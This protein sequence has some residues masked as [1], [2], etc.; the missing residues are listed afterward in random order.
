LFEAFP[1]LSFDILSH[2][3]GGDGVVTAQWVMRGTNTGPFRGNPP[4]GGTVALPGAD[5]IAVQGD[6]IR[7]VQGYFDRSALVEQLGLQ[8][9]VQPYSVGPFS[10]GYSVRTQ[11]GNPTKP[12]T[13]SL[14]WIQARSEEEVQQVRDYSR[15]I[16]AEM[17]DMDG[18][19]AWIG[20]VIANR[21]FTVTAWEDAEALLQLRHGGT[22]QE[23][24][25]RFFASELGSNAMTSVWKPERINTLWVRCEACGSM[26]DYEL[27]GGTCQ[28]GEP[29]P[30]HPPPSLSTPRIGKR[31]GCFI[32][33]RFPYSPNC[34]EGKLACRET[35]FGSG[36]VLW[37]SGASGGSMSLPPLHRR[38]MHH[39][40]GY[41]NPKLRPSTRRPLPRRARPQGQLLP[42]LASHARSFVRQGSGEGLLRFFGTP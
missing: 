1:D 38:R 31:E 24:M 12:G 18:F 23:A 10:F 6:K 27:S 30:E 7:S 22:H 5:F 29:L 15:P 9:I 26:E 11:S 16:A 17:V 25:N 8:A 33:S 19:I 28:C 41:Q 13:V 39:H 32:L 3:S 36:C 35:L 34:R 21:M 37:R 2:A 14:T 20:V 42:P 4:T 40:E